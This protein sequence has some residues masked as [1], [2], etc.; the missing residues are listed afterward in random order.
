MASRPTTPYLVLTGGVLIVS[1]APILIR[2][3]QQEG[4][5]SLV[6]AASRLLAATV[7]LS[8]IAL[9]RVGHEV[10]SLPWR[11]VLLSIAAGCFLALHFATW[12]TSLDYTSVAS[13]TILVTTNPLWVGLASLLLFGEQPGLK[14]IVA[15]V[16]TLLGSAL[17]TVSDSGSSPHSN[18]LLGNA[19]ALVG[20]LT[21]SGYFLIGRS[22]RRHITT[23][24]YIWLAYTTSA[25]VLLVVVLLGSH[26]FVGYST[27]AYLLVLAMALG[28]QLL[29]HTA[30][31]WS[32]RHLSATFITIAILG[33]P[34]VASVMA[35]LLFGERFTTFTVAGVVL[36]LQLMGFVVILVGIALAALDERGS[37]APAS[38]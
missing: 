37:K 28:P 21:V 7:I 12:I 29:G 5:P 34:V 16:L 25:L 33:E 32:L 4:M 6:I 9:L 35:R 22:L 24:A 10:R 15:L 19:L 31:N 30:F 17:I 18:A 26:T 3:I 2:L 11:R 36:P 8:P 1:T 20:A 27:L 13:S 23:L 38:P 14:T